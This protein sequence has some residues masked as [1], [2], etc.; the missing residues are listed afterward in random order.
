MP[1]DAR[2][3][4][5]TADPLDVLLPKL[6]SGDFEAARQVCCTFEPY[7]R[8]VVRRSLPRVLRTKFDSADVVQSVWIDVFTGFREARWQFRCAG[9][10]KA[11]LVKATRNRLIDHYRRHRRELR[12]QWPLKTADDPCTGGWAGPDEVAEAEELW[13]QLLRLCPER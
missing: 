12:H 8:L 5:M 6:Q 1:A 4:A 13:G 10:L 9:Q 11:F 3:E 2:S 7:L